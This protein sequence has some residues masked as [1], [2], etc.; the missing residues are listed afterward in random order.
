MGK[1]P[2]FDMVTYVVKQ[3][4]RR[5]QEFYGK[6]I[7]FMQ[8]LLTGQDENGEQVDAPRTLITPK[9]LAQIRLGQLGSVND[10][11]EYRAK[12]VDTA[13]AVIPDPSGSEVK[14]VLNHPLIA[15]LAK[16]T[17]LVKGALPIDQDDYNNHDGFIITGEQ[18]DAFKANSNANP[19]LRR[20]LF[21][22]L[23]K[24]K[25]LAQEYEEDV[26]RSLGNPSFDQVMGVYI[27]DTK[28]LRL[29]CVESIGIYIRSNGN[30][31]YAL[32]YNYGRLVGVAQEVSVQI[33]VRGAQRKNGT[34]PNIEAV[35]N[36]LPKI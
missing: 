12:P 8:R 35:M 20:E 2:K 24:Y 29:L 22:Y 7:D 10:R 13:V 16:N 6:N 18:A 14:Y 15:T 19:D 28:G 32:D 26:I 21:K 3:E 25:D 23:F 30:G 31:N 11:L 1:Q 17:K 33:D 5:F 4:L 34:T 27:P 9:E 36:Q